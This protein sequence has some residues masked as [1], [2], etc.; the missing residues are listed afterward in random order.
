MISASPPA[1]ASINAPYPDHAPLPV[2]SP[3]AAGTMPSS[4][5]G[6]AAVAA[7]TRALT[8]TRGC[9]YGVSVLQLMP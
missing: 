1:A 4:T 2:T 9:A 6:A 5:P 3:I 7:Y 8:G